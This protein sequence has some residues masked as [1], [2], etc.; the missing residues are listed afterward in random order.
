MSKWWVQ[1]RARGLGGGWRFF[2]SGFGPGPLAPV[3]AAT[4][5]EAC[6]SIVSK[7]D[8]LWDH[9]G[10]LDGSK[11]KPFIIDAAE[12]CAVPHRELTDAEV[13]EFGIEFNAHV[14][15]LIDPNDANATLPDNWPSQYA[16]LPI[17][18]IMPYIPE[19]WGQG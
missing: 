16:D 7:N 14:D 8:S 3:E 1:T 10:T 17:E 13:R 5:R 6:E 18:Q 9:D 11:E 15:L 4:C 2:G 12:V 19:C